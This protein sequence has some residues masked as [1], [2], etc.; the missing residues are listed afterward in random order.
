VLLFVLLLVILFGFAVFVAS[1]ARYSQEVW[2]F[3]VGFLKWGATFKAYPHEIIL[4]CVAASSLI[5]AL[6]SIGFSARKGK[7]EVEELQKRYRE[8]KRRARELEEEVEEY[9]RRVA[10]L[11]RKAKGETKAEEAEG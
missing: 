7:A 8:A 4:I 5:T 9:K 6:F 2:T 10:E 11:E 1:V 3:S